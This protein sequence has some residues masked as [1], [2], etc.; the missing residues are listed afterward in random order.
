LG[1]GYSHQYYGPLIYLLFKNYH[2][3]KKF[4][5]HINC[6]FQTIY[7]LFRYDIPRF[8]KNLYRFRKDLWYFYDF[9]YIYNLKIFRTSLIY[10]QKT[11]KNGW[12]VDEVRLKKYD[13]I[14]RVIQIL[15]N[16]IYDNYHEI[17][18]KELNLKTDY[19]ILLNKKTFTSDDISENNKLITQKTIELENSEWNELWDI[20]KGSNKHGY[21]LINDDM[22]YIGDGSGMNGWWD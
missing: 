22:M 12:E 11:I 6:F 21:Q 15:N 16:I 13:K 17:A 1:C 3:M 4:I 7:K 2:K 14:T 19:S 8:L 9:D 18:E 5:S 10:L 20:L